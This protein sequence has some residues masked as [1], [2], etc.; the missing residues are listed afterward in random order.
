MLSR[1]TFV[2]LL[3]SG[4]VMAAVT[5]KTTP[6]DASW[7]STDDWNSFNQTLGGALIKT[8]PIASS[9]YNNSSFSSTVL[10]CDEVNSNWFSS[11]LHARFPE[12]IDYPYWANNS[13]VPPSDYAYQ[14][15]GCELG[16]LPEFVLNATTAEQVATAMK[17]ASSRNIRVVVKGTGHDL[18]G[19]SSG[20]YSLSIWT[21]QFQ[22]IELNSQWPRPLGNG[23]ENVAIVGS[24]NNWG[25]LLN[26]TASVGRTLVSGGVSTVG[27]GGFIGGGGHGPLSSQYGLAADQVLQATVVTSA[28]E[29]L[30][31]NEA[32]NQDLLWA[33]RGGGPGLYGAVIEYVLRTHPSPKNVVQ[34]TLSM[35]MAGNDTQ[36]AILASWNALAT[37]SAALPDLM[38]AGLA[39]FGNA[40]T[41]KV[42]TTSSGALGQGVTATFTFFGYNTTE[43]AVSSLLAPLK[44]SMLAHGGDGALLV[45]L[46]EPEVFSTYLSFFSDSLNIVETPVG[47]ISLPSSRLLGRRELT[48]IP[49]EQLRTHLQSVM[50]TQVDGASAALV[51]GLQGGKGPREVQEHMRGALNPAWRRAYV[52]LLSAASYVNIT[53][54]TPQEALAS[55]AAWT[56]EIQEAAW[57]KWAPGSGS[58]INEANP[59]NSNF[60]EDF[61]GENYERLL[62]V[63]KKYDP[64]TSLFVLSG[65][66]SDMWKYDLDTGKLCLQ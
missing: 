6:S 24:G 66:G 65:V 21:H 23:T 60:R 43:R 16:G 13:C 62:E 5:C 47:Q 44:S 12:S 31:A 7:P 28:G 63:K 59:F 2:A 22:S 58:Y 52:H 51:Y 61:Y 19:R 64:T 53:D 1:S 20:A 18:V 35:S 4:R 33:I 9:C 55:A 49:L 36:A 54:T 30:V 40:A 48:E 57:R 38:D 34:A 56:E 50:K 41:T 11:T 46:S 25:Q 15:Q 27:L 3:L 29:V 42:Y 37:I 32:Q 39:G 17:W 10:S 26:A 8:Q 14:N 45:A